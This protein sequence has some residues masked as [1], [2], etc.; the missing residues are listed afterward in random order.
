MGETMRNP[1]LDE[2][3]QRD[4]LGRLR[5][6]TEWDLESPALFYQGW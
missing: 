5:S 2:K 1:S 3:G 6:T 4:L